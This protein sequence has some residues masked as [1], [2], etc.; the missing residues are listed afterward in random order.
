MKKKVI[1]LAAALMLLMAGVVS[2]AAKWG[3]FEGYNIVKLVI[4]GKEVVPKDTPPVILKGRTMVPLA[5]LQDAGIDVSW[6][7]D[8]YTVKAESNT[9]F[10]SEEEFI[11]LNKVMQ[12]HKAFITFMDQIELTSLGRELIDLAYTQE[13]FEISLEQVE[14]IDIDALYGWAELLRILEV[15]EYKQ[16]NSVALSVEKAKNALLK[17]DSQT[18]HTHI[19]AAKTTMNVL[20]LEIDENYMETFGAKNQER[21]K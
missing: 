14:R 16:Y 11:E 13:D 8:S 18:A 20:F 12:S 3:T 6:D 1:V 9:G 19:I 4:N 10:V 7:P 15:D 2:A 21:F 5:M 17:G